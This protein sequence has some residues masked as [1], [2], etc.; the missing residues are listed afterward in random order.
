MPTN[1]RL[2][3][4]SD[5]QILGTKCEVG[6]GKAI[7]QIHAFE[8]KLVATHH[9]NEHSTVRSQVDVRAVM[10]D[11]TKN[12]VRRRRTID[13]PRIY[14]ASAPQRRRRRN[15][16]IRRDRRPNEREPAAVRPMRRGRG[17]SRGALGA[18]RPG[19]RLSSG[20]CLAAD[21][22]GARPLSRLAL[23]FTVT[24]TTFRG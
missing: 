6:H 5:F 22:L 23:I 14:V 16:S 3:I 19:L 9:R 1:K 13:R 15:D 4:E 18:A 11:S 8:L 7:A 20:S 21:A 10:D 24:G 12:E 17:T 2:I